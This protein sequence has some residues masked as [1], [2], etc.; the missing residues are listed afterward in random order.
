[1]LG[2]RVRADVE[3]PKPGE[4]RRRPG[5][6][7]GMG[8]R[9]RFI[10]AA[11][12]GGAAANEALRRAW[13]NYGG[14]GAS[15]E[16]AA[17]LI[18]TA[19]AEASPVDEPRLKPFVAVRVRLTVDAAHAAGGAVLWSASR[20]SSALGLDERQARGRALE[21]AADAAARAAA[22]DLP[23]RLWLTARRGER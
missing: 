19:S 4:N 9:A 15:N 3:F 10:A 2:V 23:V 16:G 12:V 8:P 7:P 11:G 17:E 18:L 6:L 1:M 13:M 20:E 5:W 14:M 21:A 22:E